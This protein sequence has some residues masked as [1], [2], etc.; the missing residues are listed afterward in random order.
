MG[1]FSDCMIKLIL[2][3]TSTVRLTS[4]KKYL[5]MGETVESPIHSPTAPGSRVYEF[6][7]GL[8]RCPNNLNTSV[9]KCICC[10]V[11]QVFA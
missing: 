2:N 8:F 9:F 7:K 3:F 11:T 5:A 6:S 10:L 1:K 4:T